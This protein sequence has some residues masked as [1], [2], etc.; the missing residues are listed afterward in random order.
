MNAGESRTVCFKPLVGIFNQ[1]KYLPL[2]WGGFVLE[3]EL[4][5]NSTDPIVSPATP[6]NP[7]STY[8]A[9]DTSTQWEISDVRLV[10]DQISLDS[11][12]QNSYSEHVLSGR[13]LPIKYNTFITMQQTV[14]GAQVLINISRAV[15]RLKTIFFSFYGGD[16]EVGMTEYFDADKKK[17][18]IM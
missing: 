9:T 11:A 8:K 14:S 17:N 4:V 2:M 3:L 16:P 1:P 5:N 6:P 18:N 7:N 12:L 10:G 13:T 15:S